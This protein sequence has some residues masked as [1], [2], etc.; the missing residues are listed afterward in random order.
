LKWTAASVG[1]SGVRQYEIEMKEAK[2]PAWK[3]VTTIAVS[4]APGGT[5]YGR[6][7][8]LKF[9]AGDTA[10]T[11]LVEG[12]LGGTYFY[13]VRAENGAGVWSEWSEMS[14]R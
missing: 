10:L 9:A 6:S 4:A 2:H 11:Y 1:V 7:G 13:R 8:K 14:S 3:T 5:T 12:V